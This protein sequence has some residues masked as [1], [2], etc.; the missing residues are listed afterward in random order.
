MLTKN[1]LILVL[2]LSS[3]GLAVVA[4]IFWMADPLNIRA[5]KDEKLIEIFNAHRHAFE[6]IQQMATED[7]GRGLYLD[8]PYFSEGSKFDKSRQQEYEKLISEIHPGLHVSI[9][10]REKGMS[11]TF[12]WGGLLA[13]GPGWG[14]GIS[15]EPSDFTDQNRYIG[16][17]STNLD[18]TCALITGTT[19]IRPLETN[20]FIFYDRTD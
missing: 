14:K 7:A 11:F 8:A 5:P 9:D 1:C 4:I 2:A 10:G 18:N 13:I 20:W 16:V 19:Y 15:Y 17:I 6:E 3:V 12:A